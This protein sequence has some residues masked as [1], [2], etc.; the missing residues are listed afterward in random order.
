[1]SEHDLKSLLEAMPRIAEVVNKFKSEEVQR[2]AFQHLIGS[3]GFDP[4]D[5]SSAENPT[6]RP[7][8][9][10]KRKSG[11]KSPPDGL[12]APPAKKGRKKSTVAPTFV[13]DLNL[14]PA[15]KK[16][17]TAFVEEKKPASNQQLHVVI[18]YYLQ[19]ILGT[20]GI[21]PSHVYTCLKELKKRVPNDLWATLRVTASKT[22]AL[23]TG[24]RE[25][26]TITV[27]GENLVDHDLPPKPKNG[28]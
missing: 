13:K 7:S 19:K 28:E 24:N 18:V 26:I 9:G 21:S 1:M 5:L 6:E 8:T 3:T 12:K 14:R 11:K 15:K 27:A 4:S 10:S 22:N 16:S 2:L 20:S 23:D 25:D 17:L